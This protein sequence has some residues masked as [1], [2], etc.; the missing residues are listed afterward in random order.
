MCG[1]EEEEVA[2]VD[3]LGKTE[4]IKIKNYHFK[5]KTRDLI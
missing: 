5:K 4:L 2:L 1:A 3:L